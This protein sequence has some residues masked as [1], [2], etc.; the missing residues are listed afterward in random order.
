MP[1]YG[2]LAAG[3]SVGGAA[4]GGACANETEARRTPRR[5][6]ARVH[7]R[8]LARVAATVIVEFMNDTSSSLR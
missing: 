7:G 5:R 2:E 8:E 1:R 3:W 4:T 6:A